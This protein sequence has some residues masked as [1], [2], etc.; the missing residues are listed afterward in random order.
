MSNAATV[1]P[2]II[3][4][5]LQKGRER[6]LAALDAADS[7][8]FAVGY[9]PVDRWERRALEQ[10]RDGGAVRDAGDGRLWLDRTGLEAMRERMRRTKL[11]VLAVA[12]AA[13]VLLIAL[14]AAMR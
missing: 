6:V 1:V 9:D 4:A 8:A 13:A 3:A 10:L 11:I 12:L 2:V 7:P 5:Q 14:A